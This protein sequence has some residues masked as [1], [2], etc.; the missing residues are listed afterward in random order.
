MKG[1][2]VKKKANIFSEFKKEDKV[3][4]NKTYA[5][6]PKNKLFSNQYNAEIEV[7]EIRMLIKMAF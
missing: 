4:L 7:E 6:I 2:D 1:K 3:N 5:P